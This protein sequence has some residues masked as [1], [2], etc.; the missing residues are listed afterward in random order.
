MEKA[1][2]IGGSRG[3][4]LATAR[5]FIAEGARVILLVAAKTF[6]NALTGPVENAIE[7]RAFPRRNY[8]G[9][10]LDVLSPGP[11]KTPSIETLDLDSP[12]TESAP[13]KS[14]LQYLSMGWRL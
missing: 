4:G 13:L 8:R 12:Q 7:S 1:A 14:R 2:I 11:V 6:D 10:R 9:I 3:V 5:Q